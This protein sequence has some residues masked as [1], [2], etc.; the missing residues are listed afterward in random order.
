M[1]VWVLYGA[2]VLIW[3]STWFAIQFQ[4]EAGAVTVSIAYRF[5]LAAAL[6]FLYCGWRGLPLLFR[7]QAHVFMALQGACLFSLNYWFIYSGTAH[8]SS[9]L[10][11]ITFST[12]VIMNLLNSYLWLGTQLDKKV[13]FGALLGLLGLSLIFLPELIK[14]H[15]SSEVFS[16]IALCLLGTFMASLGN[17]FALRNQQHKLPILQ[18]NAWGMLYGAL[19]M[20]LLALLKGDSFSIQW[21]VNFAT[22]LFYLTVFGTIIGFGCYLTLLGQIGAGKAAY[23][24]LLFPLVALTMSTL[25]ESYQWTAYAIMGVALI[26]VGNL[27]V[28][29]KPAQ[30]YWLA[31]KLGYSKKTTTLLEAA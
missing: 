8:L 9:G 16:A 18:G 12:M 10:V 11:A 19:T 30:W 17:I 20:V 21:S 13:L 4:L 25:L 22:S 2:T 14:V 3:G 6:L 7:W 1:S 15:F 5:A 31:T 24:T 23:S 28:M 29:I 27:L 26:L